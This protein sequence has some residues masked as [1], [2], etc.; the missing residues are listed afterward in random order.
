MT[1]SGAAKVGGLIGAWVGAALLL[2]THPMSAFL[3]DSYP[4][5]ATVGYAARYIAL[6]AIAGI[7]VHLLVAHRRVVPAGL[8]LLA[9]AMAA[10]I[11]PALPTATP[12]DRRRATALA[13]HDAEARRVA[14]MR[15]SAI[16]GCD[17][18]TLRQLRRTPRA[19]DLHGDDDCACFV[20]AVLSSPEDD[21]TQLLTMVS[22]GLPIR[23]S[24]SAQAAAD[25][26]ADTEP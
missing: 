10:A 21:Q 17:D 9:V 14:E 7:L 26:C 19:E 2:L 8:G 18:G 24:R 6:G 16:D 25:A 3:D 4:T 11:P 12:D 5:G 20:D 15:A 13:I 1:R 22:M 23:I